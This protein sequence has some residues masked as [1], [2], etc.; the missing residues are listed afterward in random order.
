M[1]NVFLFSTADRPDKD[2]QS[3]IRVEIA[4]FYSVLR[5]YYFYNITCVGT[6]IHMSKSRITCY[7]RAKQTF[8]FRFYCCFVDN[9]NCEFLARNFIYAFANLKRDSKSIDKIR[10]EN[11]NYRTDEIEGKLIRNLIKKTWKSSKLFIFQ[12]KE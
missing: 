11:T 12:K 10:I 1:K 4:N 3:N 9:F 2:R 7:F 5:V 6:Y 8:F